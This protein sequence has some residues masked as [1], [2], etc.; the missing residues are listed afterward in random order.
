M[1]GLIASELVDSDRES[2]PE[3]TAPTI[4]RVVSAISR[5]AGYVSMALAVGIIVV[6][7]VF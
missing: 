5:I 4:D 6:F 2:K 7:F 3:F 1:Q